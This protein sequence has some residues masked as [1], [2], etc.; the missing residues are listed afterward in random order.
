MIDVYKYFCIIAPNCIIVC[1]PRL[2][3]YL[4][5]KPPE[6]SKRIM[7]KWWIGSKVQGV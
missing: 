4:E 6:G 7:G 3:I 1:S 5:K 2:S